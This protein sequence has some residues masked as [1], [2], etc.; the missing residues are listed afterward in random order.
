MFENRNKLKSFCYGLILL[1]VI[2][3]VTSANKLMAS[4]MSSSSSSSE[5]NNHHVKRE[6]SVVNINKN[7]NNISTNKDLKEKIKLLKNDKMI[8]KLFDLIDKNGK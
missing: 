6:Y 3:K 8:E 5:T 7:T 2:S 4:L 1:L